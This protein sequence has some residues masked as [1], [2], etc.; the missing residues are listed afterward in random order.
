M[1]LELAIENYAVIESIRVRFHRGLN[2]LS[3]E[4]GSGKS[5]VV[6]ALAL[7]LGGR[8]SA[9]TVRA[10]AERA[11]IAGIFEIAATRPLTAIL[12]NA[13]IQLEDHEL[14]IEREILAN[15]KSRAFVGNRPATAALLR[16]L[17]PFLGDIHGQHDQQQLFS[18]AVQRDMLDAFAGAEELAREVAAR[19][20]HW[21]AASAELEELDHGSQE[22]L[23]LADLWAFQHKEIEAV[24][25]KAGEDA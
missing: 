11:R 6:D 3:G 25:P 4:T 24:A 2:L 15:G 1:L 23:R 17:A 13:G 16:D 12:E 18:P 8:A 19:Y 20:R 21:R 14:L 9:E 5:I 7:L 10:G 22:K